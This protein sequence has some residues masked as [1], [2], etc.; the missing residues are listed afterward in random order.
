MTAGTKTKILAILSSVGPGLF[1]IG[2][3][4]GT[5]SVT[6]MARSGAEYG[7]SLFWALALSCL[8]TYILMVVYGKLTLVTGKT[9]LTLIRQN[10]THGNLLALYIMI[11]L[12]SGEILALMGFM[13]IVSDLL[14]EAG[15]L[16]FDNMIIDTL[17]IMIAIIVVMYLILLYGRYALFEKI[18][19]VFVIVMGLCFFVVFFMIKPDITEILYG[20][21]PSIPDE[22]GAFQLVAA[23]AGTTCSAAVFII[24]SI[25]VAEKGWKSD[26]LAGVCRT[27]R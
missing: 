13:G 16:L 23:M 25:L 17:W 8:F 26:Q 1:L 5:G 3:N 11:A 18:L 27:E 19:T 14:Q 6:T 9:A 12:I 24:R 22:P 4:I 21:I 15:R 7:M 2:Y 20:M 10:F